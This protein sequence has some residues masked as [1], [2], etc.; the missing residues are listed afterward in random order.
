MNHPSKTPYCSKIGIILLFAL[1]LFACK[2]KNTGQIPSSKVV[3]GVFYIDLYEEGELEAVR[4]INISSPSI[5]WRFS[6]SMK[7]SNIVKDGTE[8]NVGDTVVVFDPSEVNKAIADAQ[9]KL[10]ISGAELEKL[11]AQQDSDLEELKA[12]YEV[13]RISFEISKIKFEQAEYESDITRK[14]IQ[15]N[16][17]KA[18]I[19]L[20]RAKEQIDNR[21][22]IN[23]EE[24][25]Q[26]NLAILQDK[27]RLN[28]GYD[29][30]RQLTVITPSPGI[31]ILGR[32]WSSGNKFQVGEQVW[33]GMPL[34]SLPDLSQL[35]ANV[36]I[37][38]VD[39]AKI[40]K[41]LN[42]E[43]KPDAFSDSKFTGVVTEVA[44]LAVNK[45]GSTK[46]KVFPVSIYL[47]E[48]DKNL[49]PGLTVSCRILIEKIE[50]V[51]Y[52]PIDAI[53]TEEGIHFVFKKTATSYK[54]VEVETGRS[55]SD[56]TVIVN[57]LSEGDEVALVDPFY[58]SKT[59]K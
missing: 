51:L 12:D 24:V 50:D 52:V 29:A 5:S 57:G 33:S 48:T 44:N 18:D 56:Y 15:L 21:K 17:E 46:I 45:Q 34:I 53:F 37:N 16:L 25:K 55:N 27:A 39:I 36:K 11:I 47:N 49:L 28:E 3:K 6:S 59:E 23:I 20:Q 22:K 7:I 19:S 8:V 4:S 26:K 30:L 13:A 14:Q 9:S 38:E 58:E 40:T 42:V 32:N 35:K 43:I 54:K 41:G 2:G 1:L 31:A 10:E